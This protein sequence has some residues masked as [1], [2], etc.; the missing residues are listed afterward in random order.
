MDFQSI[1]KLSH[2]KKYA[3]LEELQL[4]QPDA[5]WIL[6]RLAADSSWNVKIKAIELLDS[7]RSSRA[8]TAVKAA[9][10]DP[11][12]LVRMTAVE[13]LG[14]IADL[15][16]APMLYKMLEDREWQCAHPLHS[17]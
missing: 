3:F 14:S 12:W 1:K 15:D 7:F 16:D 11:K 9:L 8:R 5:E 10:N 17:A 2:K 4:D 13:T 6:V